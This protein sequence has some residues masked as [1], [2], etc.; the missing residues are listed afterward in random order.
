MLENDKY[1]DI[2][3]NITMYKKNKYEINN[4]PPIM[5]YKNNTLSHHF[6]NMVCAL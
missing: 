3:Q 6:I 2:P 5:E 1:Y 4:I